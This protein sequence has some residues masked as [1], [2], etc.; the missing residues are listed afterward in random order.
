MGWVSSQQRIICAAPTRLPTQSFYII[1]MLHVYARTTTPQRQRECALRTHIRR[2]RRCTIYRIKTALNSAKFT[3]PASPRRTL[4]TI[5]HEHR[6]HAC[7][8][9]NVLRV[10]HVLKQIKFC[11]F[12]EW[13]WSC[14]FALYTK[15]ACAARQIPTTYT[16]KLCVCNVYVCI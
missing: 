7:I 3:T 1:H 15:Y 11:I 6:D 8:R 5:Q 12:N 4:A 14:E 2:A 9:E 10:K 13:H 16:T